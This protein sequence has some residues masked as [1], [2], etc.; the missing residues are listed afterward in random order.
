M[1]FISPGTW[2]DALAAKAEHPNAVPLCG[3]TDLMVELNFDQR[4]PEAILDLTRVAELGDW[5]HADGQLRL[6]GAVT[7][8]QVIDDL[9]AHLPGLAMASRTV[10]SPQIRNRGT[11]GGNLGS[12][13]PAGDAHPV[14]L[15]GDTAVEVES[16]RGPRRIPIE[17]FF[18]GVKRHALE[19]DELIRAVDIAVPSGPQQFSK[20][21]TRNAMVISVAAFGVALHPEA[22]RVGTGVGSAAPT[23]LRAREAGQF[24]AEALEE[25]GLWDSRGAMPERLATEFGEQVAACASPV[26]DVR[27]SAAYRRHALSVL[28]RRTAT[29]AWNDYRKAA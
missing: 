4:R 9:G 1:E 19:P 20:I 15:A 22:K 2:S 24:L 8:A 25:H 13:S 5:D 17:E 3:G 18:I 23:P 11:I 14:L 28:A 7:Y 26:D 21:G 12:A 10:G 27:G 6:G 16:V 29:W